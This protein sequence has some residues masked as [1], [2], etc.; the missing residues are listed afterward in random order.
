MSV[1]ATMGL[2]LIV[3]SIGAYSLCIAIAGVLENDGNVWGAAPRSAWILGAAFGGMS[4]YAWR[5]LYRTT[6]ANFGLRLTPDRVGVC[7][8][9][10]DEFV[11]WEQ[12]KRVAV[13]V[14]NTGTERSKRVVPCVRIETRNGQV[15]HV[16]AAELGSDPNVV[17]ALMQFYLERPQDRE[18][19]ADPEKAIRRFS[20]AQ[21]Q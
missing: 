10:T 6:R 17:A 14:V 5:V 15:I 2:A 12:L 11:Y 3:T 7:R 4:F 13:E 8:I 1:S 18:L 20:D 16:E 19:L 21:S 9:Y